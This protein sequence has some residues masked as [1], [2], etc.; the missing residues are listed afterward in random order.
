MLTMDL[1]KRN[2][3]IFG[4]INLVFL[5]LCLLGLIWGLWEIVACYGIG[6]VFAALSYYTLI[7]TAY[8][9]DDSSVK[10]YSRAFLR[11]VF[12]ILG[13]GLPALVLFL[14]DQPGDTKYRYL[15]ILISTVPFMLNVFLAGK[16]KPDDI[17]TGDNK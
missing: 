10:I 8:D 1:K 2:Y 4:F 5:L 11:Y 14:T 9:K 3:L 15:F 17:H 12:M 13:I 16:V 7:E 6:L